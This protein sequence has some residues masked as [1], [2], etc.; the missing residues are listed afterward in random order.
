VETVDP[1]LLAALLTLPSLTSLRTGG[2]L[3]A[4]FAGLRSF[5]QLR[6][7]RLQCCW[8]CADADLSALQS[9]LAALPHL[10]ALRLQG[11][12]DLDAPL[13]F[14]LEAP[15]LLRLPALRSLRLEF[16]RLPSLAFLRRLPLLE[17]LE[18]YSC[19]QLSASAL[20]HCLASTPRLL[21]LTLIYSARLS[22]EQ[23]AQLRPPSAL[24]PALA[25]FRY[26]APDGHSDGGAGDAVAL[27][28][29]DADDAGD[30]APAPVAAS[31][32]PCVPPAQPSD[33]SI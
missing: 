22:A 12:A 32:A 24:L 11:G 20:L 30:D 1:P 31:A 3:P 29:A 28:T 25:Q 8:E 6:T 5:T 27:I 14:R 23:E 17:E 21:D 26:V 10:T 16:L 7:L 18:L 2:V 4:C 33:Q 19:Q 15:L 9:T 13:P